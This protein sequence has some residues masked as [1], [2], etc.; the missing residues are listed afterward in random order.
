MKKSGVN[1]AAVIKDGR[2][3]YKVMADL[4]RCPGCG[5]EVY[6]GYGQPIE[7][8]QK[9]FAAFPTDVEVKVE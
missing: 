8:H 3:Y 4:H 5:S 6:A 9:E 7:S 1:I 2:V